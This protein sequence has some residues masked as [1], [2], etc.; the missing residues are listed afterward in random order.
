MGC[1]DKLKRFFYGFDLFSCVPSLRARGESDVSSICGGATSLIL[2]ILFIYIFIADMINLA[3]LGQISST[4]KTTVL[5][6]LTKIQ[7]NSNHKINNLVF[8]IGI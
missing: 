8:A 2:M 4:Y 7:R 3:N 6:M 5:F 1:A